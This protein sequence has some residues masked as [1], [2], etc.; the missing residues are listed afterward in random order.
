MVVHADDGVVCHRRQVTTTIDLR[1]TAAVDFQVGLGKLRLCEAGTARGG[2]RLGNN[3]IGQLI[4]DVVR[5]LTCFRIVISR[6][7][8]VVAVATA[9]D[10]T[11]EDGVVEGL[12]IHTRCLVLHFAGTDKG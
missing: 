6:I 5:G 7:V 2:H 12:I 3:L 1:Q 8:F 9:I 4:F 11:D 10:T